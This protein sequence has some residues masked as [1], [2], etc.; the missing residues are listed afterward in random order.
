M[1]TAKVNNKHVFE[2]D[3]KQNA[4]TLNGEAVSPDWTLIG[5]KKYH[6]IINHQ[7]LTVEL[8][9]IDE[10]GKQ[11]T[12]AVN[13]IKYQVELQNQFDALLKQL[14]MDKL[15][16]GKVNNLKAP[17]PGLVLRINVAVGDTIKKGDALLVLE[18]MKME[19]V[20]KAAGDGVVKKINAIERT[21]VEKGHVLMEFE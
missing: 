4:I 17:M 9:G 14:G 15:A 7:S 13:G 18:A 5:D 1:L 11:F 20:I 19:N 21:A 16:A 10:T 3:T 6:A 12:I 2:I 8:L